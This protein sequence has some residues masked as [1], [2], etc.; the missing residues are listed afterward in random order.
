MGDPPT[1]TTQT[2]AP[3]HTDLTL[4]CENEISNGYGLKV[5]SVTEGQG[6]E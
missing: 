5:D 3:L 4:V 1:L 2:F 6:N